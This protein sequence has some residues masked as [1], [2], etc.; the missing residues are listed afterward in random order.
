[1]SLFTEELAGEELKT[2]TDLRGVPEDWPADVTKD[3]ETEMEIRGNEAGSGRREPVEDRASAQ[4]GVPL[5][6]QPGVA[7]RRGRSCRF[8]EPKR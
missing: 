1:V 8:R 3:G 4:V 5:A 6:D 7:S 2:P